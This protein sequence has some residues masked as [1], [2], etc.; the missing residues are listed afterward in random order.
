MSLQTAVVTGV[1][2]A[3]TVIAGGMPSALTARFDLSTTA[4]APGPGIDRGR[5]IAVRATRALLDI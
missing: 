1:S 5:S 3:D 4:N 2:G